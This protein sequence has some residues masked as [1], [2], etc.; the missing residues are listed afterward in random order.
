MSLE[1]KID[2]QIMG[3]RLI[4]KEG[5]KAEVEIDGK[6]YLVDIEMVEEGVYS[7]IHN[8]KSF[9]IELIPTDGPKQYFANTA[10]ASHEIEII[11]AQSRYLQN[12]NKNAGPLAEKMIASPMPGKVVRVA[13]KEG[14]AVQQG[15]LLIVISAMKMESEYK[16]SFDGVVKKVYVSEG[17]TVMGNQ[18]LVEMD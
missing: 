12:R 6:N 1:I 2:K 18:P 7:I 5:N 14:D 10:Y 11:D 17:D 8:G 13:V 9:N 3:I 15:S 4:S 16:A